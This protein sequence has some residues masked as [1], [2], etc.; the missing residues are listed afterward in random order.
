MKISLKLLDLLSQNNVDALSAASRREA[1]AAAGTFLGQ[2]LAILDCSNVESVTTEQLTL[3]FENIPSSWDFI[4]LAEVFNFSTMT[5]SFAQQLSQWI[6]QRLGKNSPPVDSLPELKP[7]SKDTLDIFKLQEEIIQDYRLYI[8]SFL[9][10]D[11]PKVENFVRQELDRGHLWPDPLLQINP[12]YKEGSDVTELISEGILHPDCKSYFWDK[13]NNQPFRFHYHQEQAFRAAL[14]YYHYVLTTGTGSGKSL[15][16]VVPIFDDLLKN[17]EIEGVRAILVYPMNAL[18]NSQKEEIDKFLSQVPNSNIRVEQYTGQETLTKKTEI[19]ENPP[20]ILLTNYVMLELMLTRTHEEK[21]VTNPNLKFLV[22]DE[23][24]TY[25]GRQGADVALLVRK[26]RTRSKQNLL[27]IGT[28]ATMSTEGDR[29]ERASTVAKVA[30]SIFGVEVKPENVIDETLEPAIKR[31]QPTVE[32]LKESILALITP[33]QTKE[34]FQSHPLAAWIEMN[35]GL[36]EEKEGFLVRRTPISLEAGAKNL[37]E[38]TKIP[39]ET[40]LDSLRQMFLWGSQTK[41]LAFR[42]HQFISQ[43]GSVYATIEKQDKR[44]LSLE[45]QYSTTEDRLL[46]PLVFCRDCGQDYYVVRYDANQN[47]VT[48]RLAISLDSVD[49]DTEEGYLTLDKSGL[50]DEDDL[51]RLPD[52]WFNESKK[53]IRKP[54]KEYATFIPKKLQVLPNGQLTESVLQGTSCWFVPKPFIT[55]LNGT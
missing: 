44:F 32:E 22:L 8:D 43:G 17:P 50:W 1:I 31:L 53:G 40:C 35:F 26:L 6:E 14:A 20:H 23:L 55:C 37:A 18:I 19:Q 54:K 38:F 9:K 39:Y 7:L 30:S 24:H 4:E 21:L 46:Y 48:P 27:C 3:L 25:R 28:S 5:A 47:T 11:D 13:K 10:I 49:E 42:L 12:Y 41:G 29:E 52:T 15:T 2:G 51:D 34:V 45:G 36:K 33:G 16:Y